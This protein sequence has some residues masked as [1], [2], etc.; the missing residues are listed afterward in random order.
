MVPNC[1]LIVGICSDKD[2]EE[3][4]GTVVMNEDER[5]ESVRHCKWVDEIVFPAPWSPNIKFLD[6]INADLIAHDVIPYETI[7]SSDCY[8]EF[9]LTGRFLPTLRT[10]GIS[11]SSILT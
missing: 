10:E 1:Y 8:L 4:K 11:T 5:V 9:K 7:D 3:N 2:I 6:S